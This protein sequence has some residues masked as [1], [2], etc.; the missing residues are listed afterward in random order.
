MC[1]TIE[2]IKEITIPLAIKYDVESLGIF[3]SYARG[4]ATDESDVDLCVKK[5]GLRSLIKYFSFVNE[6]EEALKCHVDLIT[7]E[8]DDQSFLESVLKEQ[9]MLYER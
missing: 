2:E 3:G 7:T 1:Y 8:I 9:V 4:E 5:G 6:L